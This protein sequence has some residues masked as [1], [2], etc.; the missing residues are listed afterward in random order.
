MLVTQR[1]HHHHHHQAQSRPIAPGLDTPPTTSSI[2]PVAPAVPSAA[3]ALGQNQSAAPISL[4][5]Q[6]PLQNS[7]S[8]YR[9][10]NPA[11]HPPPVGNS[12]GPSRGASRPIAPR[13][14]R[15][16]GTPVSGGSPSGLQSAPTVWP[17][18]DIDDEVPMIQRSNPTTLT[19][20]SLISP[21][22][23]SAVQPPGRGTGSPT[24]ATTPRGMF[25]DAGINRPLS[26]HGSTGASRITASVWASQPIGQETNNGEVGGIPQGISPTPTRSFHSPV[27]SSP[28]RREIGSSTSL[29]A[30][31][32]TVMGVVG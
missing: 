4:Q 14:P 18:Y 21:L 6:I 23:T 16:P 32:D 7:N 13:G 20:A 27:R 22:N 25:S 8:T 17:P 9:Y 1:H 15:R 19:S 29:P 30:D 3:Q 11:A 5:L 10:S 24:S 2:I 12:P 28:M 31:E 26:F